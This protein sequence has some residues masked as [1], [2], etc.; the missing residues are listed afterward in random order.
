MIPL[1]HVSGLVLAGG[2]GR[3]M[4]AGG[5]ATVEKGLMLL[6]E[7]PLVA[8]ATTA[9]PPG[10]AATYISANRHHERYS[11]YG[12]VVPDDPLLGDDPGPLGGV[13]SAMQ[14]M[15]TPWLYV[16]PADVPC[17]PCNVLERLLQ[18]VSAHA[19]RL[20]YA[21]SDRPQPLFMLVHSVMLDDLRGY[22]QG[23]MRQVQRWQRDAGRAVTFHQDNNEFF[24]INTQEDLC[25][26]HQLIPPRRG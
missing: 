25:R 8:W 12:T 3:R 9:L 24:N 16:V 18:C 26:A 1:T 11:A 20:A 14:V 4:Q 17:P 15:T 7:R 21:C 23:G 2:Q 5:A 13:V 10:L 6:H 19:C 22:L